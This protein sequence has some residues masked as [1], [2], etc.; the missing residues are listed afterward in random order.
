MNATLSNNLYVT[1]RAH[2]INGFSLTP[3]SFG[4]R[5]RSTSMLTASGITMRYFYST[6]PAGHDVGRW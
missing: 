1:A 2:F 6:D 4:S 5:S 3:R